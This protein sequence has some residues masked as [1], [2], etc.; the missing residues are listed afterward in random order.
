MDAPCY[1]CGM[2]AVNE[3]HIFGAANR[4]HSEKYKL[5]VFVCYRCHVMIHK[6]YS[7][8]LKLKQQFQA[9]F[10]EKYGHDEFMRIFGR[11]Y[12]D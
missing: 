5:K 7:E 3:H 9:L 11:N 10:E 12:L 8:S 1:L 2:P 4:K 6:N